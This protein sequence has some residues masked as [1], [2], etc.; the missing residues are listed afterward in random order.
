M[1]KPFRN[2]KP[3]RETEREQ[4][5]RFTPQALIGSRRSRWTCFRRFVTCDVWA[6]MADV[7]TPEKTMETNEGLDQAVPVVEGSLPGMAGEH[8]SMPGP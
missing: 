8:A 7:T 3:F 4:L 5:H 2:S 6:A 1:Q